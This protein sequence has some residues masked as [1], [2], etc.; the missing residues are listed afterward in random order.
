MLEK[1]N[2]IWEEVSKVIKTGF[3]SEPVYNDKYL[4]TKIKSYEGKTN[5]NFHNDM[6]PKEGPQYISVFRTGKSYYPQVLLEECKY[7]A[8]EK[9][10]LK[11]IIEDIEISSDESDKEDSDEENSDEVNYR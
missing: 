3:D 4:K 1:Y 2:E 8:K 9:K 5:T 10:M 7:V 11:Y 6:V